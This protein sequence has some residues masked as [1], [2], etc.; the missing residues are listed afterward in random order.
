MQNIAKDILILF[1][2]SDQC[3]NGNPSSW[4]FSLNL[5]SWKW[6]AGIYNFLFTFDIHLSLV[7]C[8]RRKDAFFY[9]FVMSPRIWGKR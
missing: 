9:Y 3:F 6:G 2:N 8:F 5:S 1:C 7:S 4:S